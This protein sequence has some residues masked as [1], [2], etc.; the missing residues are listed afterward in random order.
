MVFEFFLNISLNFIL[1]I[2]SN[3][4]DK[5]DI[6]FSLILFNIPRSSHPLYSLMYGTNIRLVDLIT[7]INNHC[8]KRFRER[9]R[10]ICVN[11]ANVYRA[12]KDFASSAFRLGC[13]YLAAWSA[14][15]PVSPVSRIDR[16]IHYSGAKSFVNNGLHESLPGSRSCTVELRVPRKSSCI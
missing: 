1:K 14:L 2:V 6:F 9:E 7:S 4:R 10:E 11:F 5:L 12:R 13:I 16:C 15:R 3:L 8:I